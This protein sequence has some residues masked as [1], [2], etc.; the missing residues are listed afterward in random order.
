LGSE[1][2]LSKL[3]EHRGESHGHDSK[4][5][6]VLSFV[7][8]RCLTLLKSWKSADAMPIYAVMLSV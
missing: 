8:T 3:V 6:H 7:V 1:V 2:T 4:H 5:C